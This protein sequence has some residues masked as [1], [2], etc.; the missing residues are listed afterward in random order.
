MVTAGTRSRGRTCG[1]WGAAY[2]WVVAIGA[3]FALARF[4]EAF[5]VLR[6]QQSGIA[7]A[8]VPLVMVAMN[9]VYSTSAYPVGRLSDRIGRRGLLTLGLA[10]LVVADLILA[11]ATHWA[12]V[13]GGVLLWG[14]H[15]GMTQGLLSAMVADTAPADLRGTAFGMFNLVS[16]V[17]LLGA[18]ALAGVAL[19][20]VR[21][22]GN[23]C[24]GGQLSE[25]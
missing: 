24:D 3:V 6:A 9:V 8:L 17:A 12:M 19:G 14:A 22:A 11:A 2:W 7:M 18:S 25:P 4:S 23:L 21:R 10:V 13:L 1:D 5:L 15:L 20:S 16:G